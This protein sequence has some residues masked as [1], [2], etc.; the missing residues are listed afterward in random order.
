MS[1][2]NQIQQWVTIDNQ[3]KQ[4]NEQLREL[5]DQK[6]ELNETITTHVENSNLS[7][8][9]VKISDGRIRF[10]KVKDTQPLTF[11]YLE[12][13]LREIIKNEEQVN[14]ILDYIKNKREVKYVSEIKRIYNN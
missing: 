13:C 9:T 14:K 6:N 4:L 8:A 1:F 3:I 2:E 12:S 7:N 11:K 10:V 5:R